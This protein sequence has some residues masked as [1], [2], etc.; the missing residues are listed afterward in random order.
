MKCPG[1]GIPWKRPPSPP[2]RGAWIEIIMS[3]QHRKDSVS[4]PVRG[5]WI[6]I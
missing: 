5:A 4:P 6:E 3:L 1:G 2:V